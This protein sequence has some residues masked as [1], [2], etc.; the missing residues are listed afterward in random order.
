MSEEAIGSVDAGSSGGD[1]MSSIDESIRSDPSLADIRDINGLAKSYVHAQRMVGRDKVAIPQEGADQLEWDEF[2]NRLGRPEQ[3]S[4][5]QPQLVDGMEY[6]SGMEDAMKQVMHQAGL[7]QTQA[8]ALYKG[9]MEYV[10][11]QGQ[12]LAE[13]REAVRNEWHAELRRD[14]GRAFNESV[15][16][17]Q[18][19]AREYGGDEFLGWLDQSGMGDHPMMVKM[20]AKIGKQ[21][22]EGRIADG[23]GRRDFMMTPDAARQEIARLQRDPNFMKQ[24]SSSETDGHKEALEKMQRLFEFAYPDMEA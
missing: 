4:F 3:Y 23:G 1:W 11:N 13:G 9:Y 12:G 7:T 6:D 24:Y 22:S 2:Y 18:R 15:D 8:N 5:E 21:M 10:N 19:A 16:L 17:A 20:F 14:F